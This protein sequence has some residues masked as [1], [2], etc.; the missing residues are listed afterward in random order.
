[1][2]QRTK[3]FIVVVFLILIGIVLWFIF[4][5]GDGPPTPPLTGGGGARVTPGVPAAPTFPPVSLSRVGVP[6]ASAGGSATN[7]EAFARSFAERYGSYSNQTNFENLKDLFP[8]MTARLSQATAAYVERESA[9][10]PGS[11]YFG[12]STR[13][14][15]ATVLTQTETSARLRL[16]TQRAES[17]SGQ[18]APRIYYQDIEFALLNVGGEWKVDEASWK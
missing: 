3:I 2:S 18:G 12:V 11:S 14:V 8:F 13:A 17:Q 7:I 4:W 5:R 16:S 1:M 10:T 6:G 15:S 9:K